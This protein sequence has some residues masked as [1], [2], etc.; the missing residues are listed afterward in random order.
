MLRA[1]FGIGASR[2]SMVRRPW[3]STIVSNLWP[4]IVTMWH[5]YYV[6]NIIWHIKYH[7]QKKKNLGCKSKMLQVQCVCHVKHLPAGNL[8]LSSSIFRKPVACVAPR[9]VGSSGLRPF[10]Q[11]DWS[12]VIQPNRGSNVYEYHLVMTKIA[13]ERSTM[14]KR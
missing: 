11:V 6:F 14:F 2:F 12:E 7:V 1:R 13:M 3:P 5:G 9:F 4:S 8:Q 10:R